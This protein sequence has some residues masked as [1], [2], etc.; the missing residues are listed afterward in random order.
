MFSKILFL[1]KIIPQHVVLGGTGRLLSE[2]KSY[3]LISFLLL[4]K[5]KYS[6]DFKFTFLIE[7]NNIFTYIP[8]YWS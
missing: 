4:V 6:A 1:L 8:F 3:S 2:L 7:Y 5:I